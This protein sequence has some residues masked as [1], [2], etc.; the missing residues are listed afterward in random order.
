M[1][2]CRLFSVLGLTALLS[3]AQGQGVAPHSA[4]TR[5]KAVQQK[6]TPPRTADGHPDR[7]RPTTRTTKLP[8]TIVGRVFGSVVGA[9]CAVGR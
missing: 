9:N 5:D 8:S 1:N 3:L 6:W 2:G 7:H 4:S